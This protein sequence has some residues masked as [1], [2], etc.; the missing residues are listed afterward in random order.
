LARARSSA[1]VTGLRSLA[2]VAEFEVD[3]VATYH[4][5]LSFRNS[6]SIRPKLKTD[7]RKKENRLLGLVLNKNPYRRRLAKR[8]LMFGAWFNPLV[9]CLPDGHANNN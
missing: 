7:K 3:F 1:I 4:Y 9:N 2:S 5:R 8:A 6:G